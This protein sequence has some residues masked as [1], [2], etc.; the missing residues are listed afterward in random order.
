VSTFEIAADSGQ[1]GKQK[2][3][4]KAVVG[5]SLTCSTAEVLFMN[6][7]YLLVLLVVFGC[8]L[9]GLGQVV[10][11]DV[12]AQ[13]GYQ[14]GPGDEITG[15][16]LGEAQFDFVATVDE[17]GQIEVPFFEQPIVAKC[18]SERELRADVT[19]LLSKYLRNPQLSLRVTDRK[20]RPPASVY[21][22]VKTPGQVILVRRTTLLELLSFSGGVNEEA[23]GMVQVFRTRPPICSE[24][25]AEADWK[26]SGEGLDVPS[27]MY[28]LS[29]LRLG[30][31][32]ANPVIYPGDVIVIQ[33]ASPVYITGEVVNPQGIYLKEGGLSLT[34]AIAKIGGVRREAKTKDVKIY[35]LKSNSKDREIITANYD[36]IRK[37]EQKDVMLEP[38]DIVEVDKAKDNIGM[39]ILKIA[40]GA[41]KTALGGFGN[42]IPTRVL[43]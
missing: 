2:V 33:K 13:K 12:D 16:V 30:K 26:N 18:L 29:S 15:K 38:Y 6:L 40:I 41:G 35:R 10:P 34:E 11:P 32:E 19:K 25:T 17:N 4:S 20:S 1:P 43:Y 42:A 22:E 5:Y 8:A 14:I 27:R 7:R 36:L 28:S 31:E 23:G 39:A 24:D 21:G 3:E 37:G 9:T